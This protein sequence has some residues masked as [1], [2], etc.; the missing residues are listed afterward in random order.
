MSPSSL[1]ARIWSE[2]TRR[3]LALASF[4][5]RGISSPLEAS[6]WRV[7]SI[8]LM[9]SCE[10]WRN[11]AAVAVKPSRVRWN[12][13]DVG[14]GLLIGSTQAG[15]SAL[16]LLATFNADAFELGTDGVRGGFGCFVDERTGVA[17]LSLS[18]F[19]LFL[20]QRREGLERGRIRCLPHAC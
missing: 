7:V 6:T 8:S 10:A 5:S 16:A 9:I 4:A 12:S 15:E 17:R 3:R 14:I 18:A 19:K 1:S 13:V 11:C 20:D 2:T